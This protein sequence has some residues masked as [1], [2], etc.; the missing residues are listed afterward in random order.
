MLPSDTTVRNT[1]AATYID[2]YNLVMSE[3]ADVKSKIVVATDTW[4]TRAMT[5]T[6]AGTI[7]SWITSDWEPVERVLDFHPIEDKENEGEYAALGL[8]K[9]LNDF[10]VLEKLLAVALD[11]ASPNDV[12]LR[13]LARLLQEKF[14]LQFVPANS[15]IRCL[16]HVVNLVVQKILAALGDVAD[17]DVTDDYLPNKDVPFHYNPDNDPA[18][19]ELEREVF[20]D[21][22]DTGVN[23]EDKAILL[24]GLASEFKKMIPLQKLRTITT[25]ICSSPQRRKRFRTMAERMFP[26]KLALSGWK[27]ASLMVVQDVRHHWNYTHAMIERA[28]LLRKAIDTW[29]FEKEE[30]RPLFLDDNNW[31]LLEALGDLLKIFTQGDRNAPL[32]WWKEHEHEFLIISRMAR[33]FL[34]IPGTSFSVEH[35][36]SSDAHK[37]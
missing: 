34:A 22:T 17:P 27:L 32:T 31:K 15:Q 23:E 10:K 33:N 19:D 1:L 7:A 16:A 8:V 28:L 30:L 11:N 3:L 35:L 13:A 14:D 5:Y 26:D 29:V 18:L 6:F 21:K 24:T 20:D 12:L 25:K 4:T 2:M 37:N 36:F 9:R